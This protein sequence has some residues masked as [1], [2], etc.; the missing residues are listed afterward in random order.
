MK[1]TLIVGC[2]D[3]G[4]RI[5]EILLVEKS[6]VSGI[7]RTEA[8]RKILLS[9]QITPL[10]LDLDQP[11]PPIEVE[12][13]SVCYLAPPPRNGSSDSRMR[14]FLTAIQGSPAHF[15]Y[16]STTGV[17]GNCEGEW[18]DE[19]REPKPAVDRARRRLDAEQQV[20]EAAV[21]NGWSYNIIRVAGIYGPGRLPL[22]RLERGE[23]MIPAAQSPWTNRIHVDDLARI[24]F[25]LIKNGKDG[26]IYNVT[27]GN[28]GKMSDY[29]NRIAD[30]AGMPR[31]PV[32]DIAE[33]EGQLSAGMLSYLRESRRI[34]NRK[35][36]DDLEVELAYP[37]LDDGLSAIFGK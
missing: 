5:A 14:H 26:E 18:I 6:K 7:V 32:I 9:E 3:L 24:C 10:M 22:Q 17:Y 30:Y 8:S 35:M 36:L 2:G 34:S 21:R 23:P 13:C 28:P 31:P 20:T 19:S 12:D 15:L 16:L 1:L 33:A 27:D 4:R 37:T 11:L 25:A 29:F